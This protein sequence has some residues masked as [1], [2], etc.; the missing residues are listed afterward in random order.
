MLA[1]IRFTALL[2][3]FCQVKNSFSNKKV[4]KNVPQVAADGGPSDTKFQNDAF[5]RIENLG[6]R[7]VNIVEQ[8]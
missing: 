3:I 1:M 7:R 8:N 4:F 2:F 5:I 6:E